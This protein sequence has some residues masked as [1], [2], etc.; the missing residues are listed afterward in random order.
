[1]KYISTKTYKHQGSLVFPAIERIIYGSSAAITLPEEVDRIGATRVFMIVSST[2]NTNTQEV[3]KVCDA[4]G[5]RCVGIYDRITPHNPIDTAL[6]A[7]SA[8]QIVDADLIVTFG[9]GSVTSAG[10]IVRLC[11]QHNISSNN[12]HRLEELSIK[13]TPTGT[14]TL[15]KYE[16]PSVPQISIPTTLSAGEYNAEGGYTDT[17]KKLKYLFRNPLLVPKVTILDPAPTIS[18]PLW[19]WLSTGLRAID[20]AIEGI[21]SDWATPLSDVS[22]IQALT[23][24]SSGLRRVK[25]DPSNLK[26]RLDCQ[27]GSWLSI[28][29]RWNGAKMGASHAIGHALGGVCRIPHGYTSCVMLPSVLRYN[30][31]NSV[32]QERQRVISKIFGNPNKDAADVI[33]NFIKELD[34]PIRLSDVG[35]HLDQFDIIAERT[36][37]DHW[38][39]FNPRKITEHNQIIDILKMA[40]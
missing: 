40:Y 37:R 18:T 36:L 22:F 38:I 29:G 21:C 1:M 27:I 6:E 23:M 19:V 15:P 5:N 28:A 2:M 30:N 17:V 25:Q 34:L 31:N 35:V 10:K 16:G 8:A 3:K 14:L 7:T 33:N 20:H 4:I 24:L 26:A 12:I 11:M 39:K 32:N 13:V 9:G